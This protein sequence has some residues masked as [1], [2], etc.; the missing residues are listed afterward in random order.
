MKKIILGTLV[1]GLLVSSVGFASPLSKIEAGKGKVDASLSFGSAL[2][3]DGDR[4]NRDLG[5]DT[6]YRLG[7]TYGVSDG[8]AVDYLYASHEGD[9]SSSVQSHQ[10]NL[11]YQLNPNIGVFGGY[12]Y[13]KGK[14]RGDTNSTSGFQLG[15]IG[16]INLSEKTNAWAKFGAGN[17]ITQY[18]IGLGYDIAQNWEANLFYNDTKYKD[19]D[20]DTSFKTHSINLGATYKF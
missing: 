10:A 14:Y 2:K 11:L 18:E 6:R 4:I 3:I 20:D 1:A 13:N 8:L 19:F 7:M 9:H 17:T 15:A 5:G 16:K 12:V